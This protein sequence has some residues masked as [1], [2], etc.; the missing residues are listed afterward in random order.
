VTTIAVE[1]RHIPE[2]Q[3]AAVDQA[4]LE[5]LTA[6][7]ASD[8]GGAVVLSL[9]LIGDR[10]GLFTALAASGPATAGQL[11]ERTGLAERY[12]REWLLAMAAAG[13]V[14]YAGG[15]GSGPEAKRSAR[16]RLS[17]EQAEAFTDVGSPAYAG[18]VVQS[19]TAA[20]RIVD[21]LT[22]AFR[23]GEGISWHE[24]HDD[25]F[26]GTERYFR[27]RYAASLT[28]A[29]IPS[30]AGVE[31]RLARGARVADVGAGFG[32]STI[33]M[34]KAYPNS[35][36]TAID[37]HGPSIEKARE[38]AAAAGVADRVTFKVADASELGGTYDFIAFFDSLHDMADPAAALRAARAALAPGGSVM[39]V[40]PMSWDTVEETLSN[41]L[42]RV[43]AG[44]S[45]LVCLPSGLSGEPAC[46]LGNQP[47]PARI[48]QLAKEAGFSHARVTTS[49]RR[50]QVFDLAP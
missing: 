20:T 5:K 29:V 22:S 14:T 50:N 40:E 17:P 19:F 49:D 6:Q 48:L 4:R 15:G 34:A 11:A 27:P 12:L 44:S 35:T 2:T 42:A 32:A 25:K 16:Y 1:G 9:A 31:E 3:Q 43:A 47:G 21:R 23:T 37:S 39:L 13:Y 33:I 41:P 26:E 10:L 30:L 28:S 8:A 46:G 24:Q 18:G 36:F 38:R 45:L 7:V